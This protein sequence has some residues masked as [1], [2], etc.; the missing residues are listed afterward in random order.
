[1]ADIID[2]HKYK[3]YGLLE[4]PEIELAENVTLPDVYNLRIEIVSWDDEKRHIRYDVSNKKLKETFTGRRVV[5]EC[6]SLI[7]ADIC[8]GDPHLIHEVYDCLTGGEEN[9]D[10][11]EY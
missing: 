6:L 5:F 1:M 2:F 3:H 9:S 10:D 8:D 11:E 4:K 7:L